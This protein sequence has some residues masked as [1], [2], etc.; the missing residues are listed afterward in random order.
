MPISWGVVNR[1]ATS[2]VAA[3]HG[4]I[5]QQVGIADVEHFAVGITDAIEIHHQLAGVAVVGIAQ[6]GPG[7]Q[8]DRGVVL[9]VSGGAF[10][11]GPDHRLIQA[12]HNRRV[13]AGVDREG[14]RVADAAVQGDG[15]TAPIRCGWCV[16]GE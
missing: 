4:G 1:E 12:S 3:T 13:V 16:V 7:K 11:L 15:F 5:Q 2:H 6:A 9:G 14:L 10:G 8:I